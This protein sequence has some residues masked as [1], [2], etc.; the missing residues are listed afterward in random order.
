MQ[1]FK[2]KR[3]LLILLPI[4]F[5]ISA[6][7]WGFVLE[8][9]PNLYGISRGKSRKAINRFCFNLLKKY[10]IENFFNDFALI[11]IYHTFYNIFLLI[12]NLKIF[13]FKYKI[14]KNMKSKIELITKFMDIIYITHLFRVIYVQLRVIM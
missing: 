7:L 14:K 11:F 2:M 1:L 10:T 13:N 12:N 3:F 4:K 9:H 5:S 6:I 8:Q